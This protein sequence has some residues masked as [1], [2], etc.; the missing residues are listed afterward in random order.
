MVE[1]KTTGKK[2]EVVEMML[3]GADRTSLITDRMKW[4][5]ENNRAG[6]KEGQSEAASPEGMAVEVVQE[7]IGRT[8][9]KSIR[10]VRNV[11]RI[12]ERVRRV[13]ETRERKRI[14]VDGEGRVHTGSDSSVQLAG[15]GNVQV[16]GQQMGTSSMKRTEQMARSVSIYRTRTMRVRAGRNTVNT[17]RNVVSRAKQVVV[18]TAKQIYHGFKSSAALI[19]SGGGVA[20]LVILIVCMAGMI[21]GSAFGI[22]FAGSQN[23]KERTIHTVMRE[24]DAEYDQQIVGIQNGNEYDILE[25]HGAKP[26]WKEVLAVYA[27]KTNLDPNDSDELITMTK[28]KEKKLRDVFWDMVR[29]SSKVGT[30]KRMVTTSVTDESRNAIEKTEEK[31]VTVLTI[32]TTNRSANEMAVDYGFDPEQEELLKELLDNSNDPLWAGIIY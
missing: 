5:Y 6:S 32:I 11:S 14:Y 19:A 22:F 10:A 12:S 29:I 7:E 1:K 3:T 13:H 31:D 25:M 23:S 30:E 8:P 9:Q 27:V 4:L 26:E 16:I 21:F 28:K 18:N 20:V 24:L 2:R 17:T 15:E